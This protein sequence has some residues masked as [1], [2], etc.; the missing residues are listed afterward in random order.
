MA[1]VELGQR[2]ERCFKRASEPAERRRFSRANSSASASAGECFVLR[3]GSLGPLALKRHHPPAVIDLSSPIPVG[4][5]DALR[6]SA[7]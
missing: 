6:V 1:G 7:L 5:L 4:P 3:W 2:S